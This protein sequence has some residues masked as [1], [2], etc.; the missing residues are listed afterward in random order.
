MKKKKNGIVLSQSEAA[1]AGDEVTALFRFVFGTGFNS[2]A[3]KASARKVHES[4]ARNRGE[5]HA[6]EI[7]NKVYWHCVDGILR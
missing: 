1:N 4:G 6:D 5:R 2:Y 3:T 7:R